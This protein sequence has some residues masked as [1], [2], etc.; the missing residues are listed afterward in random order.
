MAK[1]KIV[2]SQYQDESIAQQAFYLR[3]HIQVMGDELEKFG[4][5]VEESEAPPDIKAWL[6]RVQGNLTRYF[7]PSMDS[8]DQ[9]RF[10]LDKEGQG[11]AE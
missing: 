2:E 6:N 10:V 9:V 11:L 5:M 7:R 4:K 3:T 8:L 1:Q